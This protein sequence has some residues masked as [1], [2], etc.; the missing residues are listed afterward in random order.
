MKLPLR[1]ISVRV[2]WHDNGW[3]GHICSNPRDNA[4]CMFL[5]RIQSKDVEFEEANTN[6]PFN[7]ITETDDGG[8]LKLPPCIGEKV[9]FMSS[10]NVIK[11]INHPYV[12]FE[13]TYSHYKES[14]LKY[15]GHSFSVI[16]YKW[17]LKDKETKENKTA[18]EYKLNYDADLEPKLIFEDQWVQHY[19]NQKVLLDT[20]IS[21]IEVQKSLVFVYA[22]N[23]PFIDNVDR[24]LIGVGEVTGIGNLTEYEYTEKNPSFRSLLWERPIFHSIRPNFKNG[25]LLPYQELVKLNGQNPIE[26]IDHY[27]AYCPNFDEFSFGSELVTHDSA[28]D[29]LVNLRD[30]LNNCGKLLERDYTEQLNWI[31][32]KLSNIWNMRGAFPGIGAVLSAMKVPEGNLVAWEIEKYIQEKDKDEL[33]TNPWDLV[34]EVFSGSANWLREDL[35]KQIGKSFK[36]I[37]DKMP[38]A[39]KKFIILLSRLSVN[40]N[41]AAEL[42]NK[43]GAKKPFLENPYL[44]FEQTVL[45]AEPILFNVVD[46]AV[47]SNEKIQT[48]FPLEEPSLVEELL[49]KRR[50][51]ALVIE[52]LEI[53]SV[54]GHSLLSQTQV[55]TF[56]N[57]RKLEK[58]CEVTID[59]LNY[60]EDDFFSEQGNEIIRVLIQTDEKTEE[61]TKYYK[62]HRLQKLKEEIASDINRRMNR[63][64]RHEVDVDWQ[65]IISDRFKI[66]K[67]KP[68]CYQQKQTRANAEK[69]AALKELAESRFSILIGPAGTGKTTLLELLCSNH[70][71]KSKKI[72]QLAPTGKAR[73]KLSK[74][75]LTVAQFLVLHDRYDGK[76]N[77]YF[78]DDN[79]KKF[80]TARTVIIDEASMLT[81]DQL[82][83]VINT[84]VDVDRLILVGDPRQLPPIG[85]GKPFVDIINLLKPPFSAPD[86]PTIANGYAELKE[87]FRQDDANEQCTERIDV[88]LSRWF[89]NSEVRKGEDIFDEIAVHP[90]KDWDSL[91]LISWYGAKELEEKTL[92]EIEKLLNLKSPDDQLSFDIFFGG[93]EY[94]GK[95]Y[96]NNKSAEQIEK[97][98]ILSP[99]NANGF[100]TKEINRMIQKVFRRDN[101]NLA[102]DPP[103]LWDNNPFSPKRIP[104]PVGDDN[105]VY[106]DKVINLKNTKWNKPWHKVNPTEAKETSLQYFANGEIG[107]ITGD[108]RSRKYFDWYFAEKKNGKKVKLGEP[109]VQVTFSSQPDYSYIY[110]PKSFGEDGEL[111]FELAYAITVHKSQGSGFDTVF[112]ILPNPCGILSRELF[113]T[114]L[115]RQKKKIVVFHQGDFKDFKKF[116]G[117]GW[118]ETGRR[119]TDLFG[120]PELRLVKEKFYDAKYVQVSANGEFMI[121]KS[122]V[123]IADHL[124]YNKV[125]YTYENE[126]TDSRGITIHPD[127]TI[128]DRSSGITYY[129]E[130]LGLLNDDEYRKK[131]ERKMEWYKLSDIVLESEAKYEDEKRL[132]IT[133]DKPD[134]GIDSQEVLRIIKYVIKAK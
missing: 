83:A 4:S 89:S 66:D 7:E 100:G 90:T 126:I 52:T 25:F 86:K 68:E 23:I 19:S 45:S 121:S 111:S 5:P 80:S 81:E 71:I 84:L 131:W 30:A 108:Y 122:E 13:P 73:V 32:N 60:A 29:A 119:L 82:A 133:K 39:K 26:E 55:I 113:Y 92:T 38:E 99:V 91:K 87:I 51:R 74:D 14:R 46:K 31:N 132:I 17:M 20:F 94:G 65:S 127:F 21:A 118:S 70:E 9:T 114:A 40:N 24:V 69:A 34:M 63:G 96:F 123:I 58:P 27:I 37:W 3:N 106:G 67:S 134:G 75:A 115:T 88:R 109:R 57:N 56:I 72:L 102:E 12:T 6:K 129:W 61:E 112:F 120:L 49:D 22:K 48:A 10:F 93:T 18:E 44:F 95:G 50:V 15:P 105:M 33:K 97:W 43:E 79:A 41:Q 124:F 104:L 62:L 35:Q 77:R 76:T 110:N 78:I 53:A 103:R 54:Q 64:K 85:T 16:P 125:R 42:Y 101:I 128:E 98:Q 8:K 2:P 117:D 116:I 130:H 107:I 36:G 1:H 47:F 28:I 59:I 11:K